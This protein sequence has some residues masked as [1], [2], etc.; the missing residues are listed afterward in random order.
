MGIDLLANRQDRGQGACTNAAETIDGKLAVLSNFTDLNIQ[1]FQEGV[2]NF[3]STFD[4]AGSTHADRDGIFALRNHGEEGVE[5]Y[6]TI[7]LGQGHIH[8]VSNK[9]LNFLGQVAEK[10]LC[11]VKHGN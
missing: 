1:S 11:F 4:E 8:V 7:Y 9:L 10:A 3:L 2:D 5:T 6:N